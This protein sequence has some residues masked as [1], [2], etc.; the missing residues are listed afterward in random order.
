MNTTITSLGN[1]GS[2]LVQ[3][4][5]LRFSHSLIYSIR[6]LGTSLN[7]LR[8]LWMAN[9]GLRDLDGLASLPSLQVHYLCLV[10]TYTL[11]KQ[12]LYVSNNNIKDVS[13]I[14]LLSN[15]EVLDIEKYISLLLI[16]PSLSCL[17]IGTS[18]MILIN[19]AISVFV[20]ISL[21]SH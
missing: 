7:N 2:H 4:T 20:L 8:V 5:Q 19:L 21:S 10:I 11:H 13:L 1:F 14:S 12:E 9:C 15:L 18:S 17:I 3:L 16:T 6:D